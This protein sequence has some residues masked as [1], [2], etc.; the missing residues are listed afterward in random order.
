MKRKARYSRAQKRERKRLQEDLTSGRNDDSCASIMTGSKQILQPLHPKKR[1]K[2]TL[3]QRMVQCMNDSLH[4]GSVV[5]R[6]DNS[7]VDDLNSVSSLRIITGCDMNESKRQH[8]PDSTGSIFTIRIQPLLV[9]D[10]NGIL[11]HRSRGNKEPV[12]IQLRPSIGTM[13]NTSII[14]RTDLD[15]FLR[16]L[17]QH[18]C[19]AIWTSAKRRTANRLVNMLIPGDIRQRLLFIWGQNYC[20]AARATSST[21]DQGTAAKTVTAN[22]KDE[23]VVNESEGSDESDWDDETLFKK[24]LDKVWK[25]FPLW[26]ADNT[27]LIDDTREKCVFAIGNAI[28][29]PS[30]HGQTQE[31]LHSNA[32]NGVSQNQFCTTTVSDE[33]NQRQQMEFFQRLGEFWTRQPYLQSFHKIHKVKHSFLAGEQQIMSNA[34]LY[35]FLDTIVYQHWGWGSNSSNVDSEAPL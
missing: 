30:I 13:A 27:L 34:E 29:P 26:S 4:T 15:D 18:F 19:I 24:G 31:S 12:N 11:C 23:V 32:V 35:R 20:Q 8:P 21:S 10:L 25:D 16:Y 28:H 22:D 14:P 1:K 2:V 9:L 3:L 17:D 5:V 7:A 6:D 33:E